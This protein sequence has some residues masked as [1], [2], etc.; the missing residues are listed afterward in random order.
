MA[1]YRFLCL[2][3]VAAYGVQSSYG[4]TTSTREDHTLPSL[5]QEV[6]DNSRYKTLEANATMLRL[7]VSD[8]NGVTR[9]EVFDMLHSRDDNVEHID[10]PPFPEDAEA[11]RAEV[12]QQPKDQA[13]MLQGP[14]EVVYHES[15]EREWQEGSRSAAAF[16]MVV[17][18]C[19][20]VL[21]AYGALI[22]WRRIYLQRN[23]LKHEQLKNEPNVEE[24][25]D[26]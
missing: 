2:I 23:G 14:D 7:L 18:V 25:F 12:P 24:T 20:V 26:M 8:S 22:V 6:E 5:R 15:T 11:A 21:L 19:A 17:V 13:E 10:L 16:L 1:H 3:V 4:A 9:T